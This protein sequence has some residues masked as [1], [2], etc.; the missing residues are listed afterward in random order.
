MKK[1]IILLLIPLFTGLSAFAGKG[2]EKVLADKKFEVR[3][4]AL[5]HVEH[6]Y[7]KVEC[8][9]GEDNVILVKVTAVAETSDPAKAEKAF[10]LITVNLKGDA[11]EVFLETI[12]KGKKDKKDFDRFTVNVEIFMPVHV[13]LE[14]EQEFGDLYVE[15][16]EGETKITG[17]YGS[18]VIEELRNENNDVTVEFGDADIGYINSGDLDVSYS[19]AKLQKSESL[20]IKCEFSE[21]KID[22]IGK[23]DI[24]NQ[25]GNVEIAEL[26]WAKITSE[27]SDFRIGIL[28]KG[29]EGDFSYGNFSVK[30]V[31]SNF[32]DITLKNNFGEA[33]LYFDPECVFS[34][35]AEMRMCHLNYPDDR[36]NF[37]K[38][39]VSQTSSSYYKGTIGKGT[40]T[41]STVE[42][43]SEFGGVSLFF[44]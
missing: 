25:G 19:N 13:R 20:N 7:G 11:D 15:T 12:V 23:A 22:K 35:D 14:L 42:I 6:R 17:K 1:I 40:P 5:L 3:K 32:G 10:G 37:S 29:I 34:I 24:K 9:N 39:I 30:K 43:D 28:K 16:V 26:G 36:A 41:G 38:R 27:F 8:R 2:I 44:R 4:D 33:K 21:L 18:A 31:V